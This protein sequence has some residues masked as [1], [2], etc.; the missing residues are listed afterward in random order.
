MRTQ[1]N[2]EVGIKLIRSYYVFLSKGGL[3]FTEGLEI[4]SVLRVNVRSF[5]RL[6]TMKPCYV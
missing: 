5:S 2:E 1:R 6:R 4:T 3:C